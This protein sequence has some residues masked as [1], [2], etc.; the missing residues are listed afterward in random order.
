MAARSPASL[1][2]EDRR[3][4]QRC[5]C[6]CHTCG[7]WLQGRPPPWRRRIVGGCRD[8]LAL[9]IHAAH[10][11]K[12]ARLPGAGGS[13][14]AAEMSLPL[15]YMRPMAARSPASLAQED[16]R[17]LQRCPCPCHTCGPWL[18]GRPPPWRR[19]IVGGCRDV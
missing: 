18:Q 10:G 14:E 17:R 3:R 6:P 16:R 8:V 7:P 12:V 5:P 4:L 1:A 11:C 9:A 19:R 13:S 2:Q 15:P